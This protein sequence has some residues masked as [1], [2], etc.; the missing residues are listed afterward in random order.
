MSKLY[1]QDWIA[2]ASDSPRESLPSLFQS[3]H[4]TIRR[5]ALSIVIVPLDIVDNTLA[6]SSNPGMPSGFRVWMLPEDRAAYESNLTMTVSMMSSFIT[7]GLQEYVS[8]PSEPCV[9]VARLNAYQRKQGSAELNRFKRR[10]AGASSAT[11]SSKIKNME[12]LRRLK[13]E[14]VNALSLLLQERKNGSSF[15]F[16]WKV[17]AST[18]VDNRVFIPSGSTYGL[19]LAPLGGL[20][21]AINDLEGS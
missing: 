11:I 16:F 5:H 7:D 19:G 15:R 1:Y 4:G 14:D 2:K 20:F 17:S 13:R 8:T 10:N 18:S 12:K 21:N 9:K 6:V 3:L